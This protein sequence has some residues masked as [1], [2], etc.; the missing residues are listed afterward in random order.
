VAALGHELA[1]ASGGFRAGVS[2]CNADGAEPGGQRLR[3]QLI[4]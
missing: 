2:R 4:G 1:Q 3:L